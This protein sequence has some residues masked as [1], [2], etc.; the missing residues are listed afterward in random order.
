MSPQVNLALISAA[1]TVTALLG[2]LLVAR[3]RPRPRARALAAIRAATAA[4][5]AAEA[6]IPAPRGRAYSAAERE[7]R[8]AMQEY[9]RKGGRLYPA[10]G[11]VLEVLRSL[12]YVQSAARTSES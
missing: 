11:E 2:T 9:L 6:R 4:R 1:L 5:R 10:W 3:R 7:L 12:G 8:Q